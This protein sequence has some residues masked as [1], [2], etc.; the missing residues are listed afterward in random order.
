M[1]NRLYASCV[2]QEHN[3]RQRHRAACAAA[4]L[5]EVNWLLCGLRMLLLANHGLLVDITSCG[6]V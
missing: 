1:V 3:R 6:Q 4:C 5:K 2:T